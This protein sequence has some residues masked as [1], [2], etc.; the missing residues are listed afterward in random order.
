MPK[1][2]N[3]QI[4]RKYHE[5]CVFHIKNKDLYYTNG[6]LKDILKK[7]PKFGPASSSY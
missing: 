3:K 4:G 6:F 2:P 5:E 1:S 7:C